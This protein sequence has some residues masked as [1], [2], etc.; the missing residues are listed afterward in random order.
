MIVRICSWSAIGPTLTIAVEGGSLTLFNPSES[1]TATLV[2]HNR[3]NS[4]ADCS[5]PH[6]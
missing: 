5:R 4:I 1:T 2:C 6:R 3:F